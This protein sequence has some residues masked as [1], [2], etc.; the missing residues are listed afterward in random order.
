MYRAKKKKKG[1][2]NWD[3]SKLDKESTTGLS[4]SKTGEKVGCGGGFRLFE[5]LKPTTPAIISPGVVGKK[6]KILMERT[7]NTLA[8]LH[9]PMKSKVISE[10]SNQEKGVS[11]KTNMR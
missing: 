4:K 11:K 8:Q 5:N 3:K 6:E 10:K 2:K 7:R 1:N 9:S